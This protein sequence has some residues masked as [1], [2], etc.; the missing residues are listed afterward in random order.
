MGSR[1]R[2]ALHDPVSNLLLALI[3]Y[4]HDPTRAFLSAQLH[5]VVDFGISKARGRRRKRKGRL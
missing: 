3:E 4:P 1:H 5:D 2:K